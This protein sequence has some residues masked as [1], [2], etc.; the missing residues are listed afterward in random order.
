M[1]T[2]PPGAPNTTGAYELD[3]A[4]LNNFTAAWREMHTQTDIFCAAGLQ[5]PDKS[6]RQLLIG[7]WSNPST[8]GIRIYTPD[9][10]A[11]VP[12]V[13]DW[14]E[15]PNVQLQDGRWYPT[16]MIMANG[17]ILVVGGEQG[18][19][20]PPVPTLEILPRTR[21]VLYMEWLQRT[22]PLNL[23]PYLAV[24]PTGGILAAYYNEARILNEVDFSTT[25]MLPGIP[26]GIN[27]PTTS[28]RTYPLE[29]TMMLL[30][31]HAPYTDP[32]GIIICGGSTFYG[33]ALDNCVSI[34][35]EVVGQDWT[36]ERMPSK[37]VM[38]CM[39]ALP[40]GTY[41]IVNGAHKGQ[42]GFGLAEDPNLNA[43]LYDP[44]AP[45]NQRMS[46]LANTTVARLYHSEAITLSDGRVLISGSDPQDNINP[47]EYRVEVF[48]PPYLLSGLPRPTFTITNTDW[49]YSQNVGFTLTSGST[50]N[51]RVSLL[52]ADASTHGATM[53]QRTIFPNVSCVGNA[54][55]ITA[56][57][58]SHISPPGWFKLY[59]LDGPMPSIAKFV[60]IGGDPAALGNWPTDPAFAPLPGI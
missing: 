44:G 1:L 6:G 13:N 39:A 12:G 8:Y 2:I 20:G 32:L 26:G 7:G 55:T 60:R 50:A 45:P 48:V 17:S 4:Q 49:A 40:D 11:G 57:P 30:P 43:V 35:P 5:L 37:R 33:Q 59:V 19:N 24:L 53:G 10:S 25:R 47:Q 14:I 58:N 46:V 34:H 31:Q 28:G 21:P 18:S 16:A 15:T 42:A 27:D 3:L 22:D 38:P 52:G 56:P 54:C 9:G 36:I 23:Y 29:G 51:L 41:L